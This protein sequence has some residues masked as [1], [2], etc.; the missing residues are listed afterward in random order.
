MD[1]FKVLAADRK[2][3]GFTV[4][5]IVAGP[6]PDRRRSVDGQMGRDAVSGTFSAFNPYFDAADQRIRQ[7]VDASLVPAIEGGWGWHMQAVG[8]QNFT[9]HWRCRRR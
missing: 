4:V 7:L 8:V 6:Y 3:K 9:R 1:G 2:S 5:Q